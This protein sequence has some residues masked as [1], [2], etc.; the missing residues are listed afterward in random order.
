MQTEDI[1]EGA[2]L[3]GDR[4]QDRLAAIRDKIDQRKKNL[5]ASKLPKKLLGTDKKLR[6]QIERTELKLKATEKFT[7][8]LDSLTMETPG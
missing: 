1:N 4:S 2:P 3:E 5:L 8:Y 7:N 6:S